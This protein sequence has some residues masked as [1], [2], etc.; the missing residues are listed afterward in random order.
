L[1][2]AG[3]LGARGRQAAA[4]PRR[5]QAGRAS[6]SASTASTASLDAR[7]LPEES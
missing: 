7:S 3:D 1:A 5:Q 4:K 2:G 6:Y